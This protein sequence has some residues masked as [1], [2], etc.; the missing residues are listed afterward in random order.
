MKK[1][2]PNQMKK[3][4]YILL[5]LPALLFSCQKEIVELDDVLADLVLKSSEDGKNG[6]E[7]RKGEACFE[8]QF[9]LTVLMPDD[10]EITAG[11][12]AELVDAIKEW[13][14]ANERKVRQKVRL[15][16]PIT[17]DFRGEIIILENER[18]LERIKMACRMDKDDD[19]DRKAC[20]EL[21]YPLSY[22]MPDRTIITGRT[23][24]DLQAAF[25]RWYGANQSDQ[26]PTLQFPV[27]INYG[28]SD[29]GRD[30]IVE[31]V[32]REALRKAY[33]DCDR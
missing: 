4:L 33:A 13:Y 12:R 32:S 2:I 18:Q 26:R 29:R 19:K 7:K 1:Y 28:S 23:K 8:I 24:E 9:P 22:F 30:R 3:L 5:V 11:S 16:Y 6:D 27:K 14:T 17:V 10:S 21:V 25:K 31:I 20:F 15:K